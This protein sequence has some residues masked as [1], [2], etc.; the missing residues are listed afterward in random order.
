MA[1][2]FKVVK[3]FFSD[4]RVVLFTIL[5]LAFE[6]ITRQRK[7]IDKLKQRDKEYRRR[8]EV[9][10]EIKEENEKINQQQKTQQELIEE[11]NEVQKNE[12]S[13]SIIDKL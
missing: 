12:T 13:D 6:L 10:K 9:A 3:S 7:T 4:V 5:L 11:V 1:K 2:I 8:A